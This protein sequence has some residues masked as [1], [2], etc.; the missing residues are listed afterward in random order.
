MKPN[1]VMTSWLLAT[2]LGCL[3]IGA[4]SGKGDIGGGGGDP[5]GVGGLSGAGSNAGS[6]NGA[7]GATTDGGESSGG[8]PGT[9]G[10]VGN[11]GSVGIGGASGGQAGGSGS[12]RGGSAGQVSGGGGT[13]DAGGSATGGNA[14]GAGGNRADSGASG[15]GNGGAGAADPII[16]PVNGPCPTFANGTITLGGLGG[17]VLQVGTKSE[18]TG[19]LIFYWHGTGSSTAEVNTLIPAATRQEILG[20]GGIIVAF[21]NSLGT[22]GDCSGTATFSKDDFNIADQIAACA[23]RDFG[24]DPHRIFTTG[25]SA[26]GLQA[27]CMGALRSSYIAATVPNSGGEVA[28]QPIQD[29]TRVPAVMTMHGG[30]Q[31]MVIVSFTQTSATYDTQMKGAGSFVIDC[32]HMGGHCQAPPAL[33]TAGWEFMKAHP[34]GVEPEPYASGLPA[35]FPT[36]CAVQ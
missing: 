3:E 26:G 9:G 5:T 32:N 18:G 29:P 2:I 34:F 8:A 25:C 11:G 7:G 16:P 21:Q 15:G 31:D 36:F 23:V 17:I 22:G 20:Q 10:S 28:R 13:R 12:A 4:C 27:G 1:R 19:S 33:Y 35:S 6:A 14:N 30:P 24:I